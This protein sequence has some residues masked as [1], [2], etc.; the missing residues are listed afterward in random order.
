[1]SGLAVGLLLWGIAG[2]TF[3][4]IFAAVREDANR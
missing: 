4:A 2:F 3:A 1:M